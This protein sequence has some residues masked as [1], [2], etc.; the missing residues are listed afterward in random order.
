MFSC[1][2]ILLL[3]QSSGYIYTKKTL[4]PSLFTLDVFAEINPVI[5]TPHTELIFHVKIFVCFVIVFHLFILLCRPKISKYLK[6][7]IN[8]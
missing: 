1:G 2:L 8:S 5:F 4:Y 7:K 6:K 3:F